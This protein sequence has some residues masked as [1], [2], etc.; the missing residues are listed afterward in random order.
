MRFVGLLLCYVDTLL[1][2]V[3][4]TN[5]SLSSTVSVTLAR[6][7]NLSL[8]LLLKTSSYLKNLCRWGIVLLLKVNIYY[9][10]TFIYRP[11]TLSVKI[12]SH[13]KEMPPPC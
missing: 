7:S 4:C 13:I 10:V 12:I 2:T 3:P 11:K 5:L 9:S 8:I 1:L 6:P